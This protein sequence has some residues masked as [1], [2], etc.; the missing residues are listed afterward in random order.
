LSSGSFGGVGTSVTAYTDQWVHV[1]G[2][3]LPSGRNT[4][5][6]GNASALVVSLGAY[7]RGN[8]ATRTISLGFE[9]VGSTSSFAVS[10]GSSAT[11]TGAQGCYFLTT[12]GSGTFRITTNGSMRFGRGGSGGPSYDSYGTSFN[13]VLYGYYAYYSCPTAPLTP[14][15]SA[16]TTTSAAISWAVP[17]DNGDAA[18]TGYRVDYS[19]SATFASAT[20][21]EVGNVLSYTVTGLASSTT[22]YFRVFAENAPTTAAGSW[23]QPSSTVSL[24]SGSGGLPGTATVALQS[25]TVTAFTYSITSVGFWSFWMTQSATSWFVAITVAGTFGNTNLL[26]GVDPNVGFWASTT[27]NPNPMVDGPTY[28]PAGGFPGT[29]RFSVGVGATFSGGV[30]TFPLTLYVDGVQVAT[31]TSVS[32]TP[33]TTFSNA[34]RQPTFVQIG[35]LGTVGSAVISRLSHT[36]TRAHEEYATLPTE[37]GYL[38]AAAAAT[39]QIVLGTLPT[40]LSPAPVGYLQSSR[41]TTLD[42]LNLIIR[43]EQGYLDTVTTGTLTNPVQTV[44]IRARQRPATVS[45]AFDAQLEVSGVVDF[46]RDSTNLIWSDFVTGGNSATQTVSQPALQARAGSNNSADT[47]AT[48]LASDLYEFG[49]DRLWRGQN[50]AL[51]PVAVTIDNRTCPTDR[52]SDLLN[53]VPGDRIQI[54]NIPSGVLGFSTWDGWLLDKEQSHRSGPA[55]EDRFVLYLQPCQPATGIYD[56][57]RYM[58]DGALTLS[59]SIASS[60]ATTMSVATTGP[61][62]ETVQVPYD[63]MVDA[64]QVTVTA[65]T[66]ATPQ[67]A[68]I[69]RGVNGTTATTHTTSATIELA[70]SSLY[71]F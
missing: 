61:K 40:D 67:V 43:T 44:R 16:A 69:T 38:S 55:A 19:T 60:G 56:T 25:K 42:A 18:V 54:T 35:T 49:T 5:F 32:T 36:L 58:A 65:C 2:I 27:T 52:S 9:G 66:G 23:S 53:M 30:W 47:V 4:M 68:T 21:I 64:E 6:N 45:Y 24:L 39:S 15:V 51:R 50:V 1:A 8:G 41:Q 14:A 71:A 57:N 33:P 28:R 37:A 29:H 70:I 10:A 59:T 12:G 48:Y 63:L 46:V 7:V 62:L 22:Y 17:S 20:S 34:A 31:G 13:N 26:F 3:S 11:D